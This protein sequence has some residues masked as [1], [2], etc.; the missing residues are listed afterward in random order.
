[1]IQQAVHQMIY[2]YLWYLEALCALSKTLKGPT[3]SKLCHSNRRQPLLVKWGTCARLLYTRLGSTVS[4]VSFSGV[5]CIA[6]WRRMNDPT[7]LVQVEKIHEPYGILYHTILTNRHIYIYEYTIWLYI[8]YF[9]SECLCKICLSRVWSLRGD[10]VKPPKTSLPNIVPW[11]LTW[12]ST[13]KSYQITLTMS[14]GHTQAQDSLAILG[15]VKE[16]T[17]ALRG[18]SVKSCRLRKSE[19]FTGE[20]E[21]QK[22]DVLL[23]IGNCST[24][25]QISRKH[26]KVQPSGVSP[27]NQGWYAFSELACSLPSD[28]TE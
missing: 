14:E 5:I 18:Q 10:P 17:A 3:M 26:P 19:S 8:N 15:K 25:L 22:T 11:K 1:M 21:F 20:L 7:S 9:M 16:T 4:P 28:S 2:W 13:Y 12:H 6:S 24:H 23:S 27:W